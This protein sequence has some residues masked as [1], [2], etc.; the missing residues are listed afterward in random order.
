LEERERGLRTVVTVLRGGTLV[1]PDWD[2][3][4]LVLRES[5]CAWLREDLG[6]GDR[7]TLAVVPP[8]VTGTAEIAVRQPGVLCGMPGIEAVFAELDTRLRVTTIRGDGEM[9]PAGTVVGQFVGP[10]RGIL[11]GERLALNLHQR[12]S[13]IATVTRRFVDAV[14]GTGVMILDTRKTTPGL[15]LLEKY[16]VRIGGGWNHRFGLFDG[17]LIK[18]NYVRVTGSV[19]EA[20]RRV[21]NAIP[22]TMLVE[23]EVTT[24]EE[25]DEAVGAGAD[26]ILL[27]NMDLETMREAVRRVAGRAKVEASGGVTLERARAIAET[28]VDAISVGALTHSAPALD[29]SLEVVAI[30]ER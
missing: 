28:G 27:D 7:T 2:I 16:A 6:Y 26:W 5:V 11:A 30:D 4:L 8:G 1:A 20:V 24:L 10:L 17:V 13:G 9:V 14:A 19:R 21:R 12:L 22:H 25:L 29:I 15:R 3:P 23:V 18:D